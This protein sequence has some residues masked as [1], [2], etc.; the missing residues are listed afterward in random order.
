MDFST[1]LKWSSTL[2][3]L[4]TGVI[5]LVALDREGLSKKISYIVFGLIL[6][7][8]AQWIAWGPYQISLLVV[9]AI[10]WVVAPVR[11]IFFDFQ[12][13]NPYKPAL[14]SS[15]VSA[16]LI[17][18][19][20]AIIVLDYSNPW[21]PYLAGIYALIFIVEMFVVRKKPTLPTQ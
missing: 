2:L 13:I 6:S 7:G 1:V 8:L 17:T 3:F 12:S 19:I 10:Y 9:F 20:L 18:V 15:I 14:W 16:V 11:L 4:T 5:Y 21:P